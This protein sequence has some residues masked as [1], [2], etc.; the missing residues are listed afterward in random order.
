MRALAVACVVL[1]GVRA[2]TVAAQDP[3]LRPLGAA[4]AVIGEYSDIAAVRELSGGRL[5]VLDAREQRIHL[6]DVA[7]GTTRALG[8]IGSGPGE[9]RRVNALLAGRG[10]TTYAVDGGNNRL[11]VIAPDGTMP[12]V[13]TQWT[14]RPITVSVASGAD[15]LGNVYGTG[16]LVAA[17]PEADPTV[18]PD[19]QALVRV[20]VATG[21]GTRV[22]TLATPPA[23][24]RVQR[25]GEKIQSVEITRPPFSTGDQFAIAPGGRVSVARRGPYRVELITTAGQ[26]T[27]GPIVAAP[28]IPVREAEREEYLATLTTAARAASASIE[29]P[30]VLPVFPL[31]AVLALDNGETWVRRNVPAGTATALYDIFDARGVRTARLSMPRDRRVVAV[32]G[33]GT[34]V[35]VTD[36][37]GLQSLELYRAVRDTGR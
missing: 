6:V 21:Q 1:L 5:L 7:T 3:P 32:S 4:Q 15:R 11:L 23:R 9:Y 37:D 27:R 28:A 13:V 36:P 22:A 29:W 20:A 14:S 2:T 19:S 30:E 26:V 10:D 16:P 35:A 34:W 18:V 8:R 33:T 17:T 24:I 12:A 31:R 25:S